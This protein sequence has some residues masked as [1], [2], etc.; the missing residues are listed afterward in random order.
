MF[1]PDKLQ[2]RVIPVDQI[3]LDPNNPRL[4]ALDPT[5][6]RVPDNRVSEPRVQEYVLAQMME[7]A[8]AVRP[9]KRS[10]RQVGFLKMDKI[11]V[12]PLDSGRYVVVEGNRRVAAIKALLRDHDTG[13]DTLPDEL[14]EQLHQLEV[15]VLTT[16]AEEASKDQWLLQGL[17]HISGVK[18]WGPYQRAKALETLVQEMGYDLRQAA[19][20]VGLG[21]TQAARALDAIV[22]L[23]RMHQDPQYGD[24]ATPDMYS[25]FEEVMKRPDLRNWLGWHREEY[26]QDSGFDNYEN[27]AFFY[28][29][30]T[31]QDDE[32]PKINRAIDVRELANVVTNEDS[33]EELMRPEGSLVRA[34][35]MTVE[36]ERA[37]WERHVRRAIEALQTMPSNILESLSTPQ[38][39]LVV[40]L[41][42]VGQLRLSQ[43]RM[44]EEPRRTAEQGVEEEGSL[45]E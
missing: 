31:P 41:I 7:R 26:W 28:S 34:V 14:L 33:L 23:E 36:A 20:T 4:L 42:S 9:L 25:Y 13:R 11:V 19:D 43:A 18:A 44:L 40:E 38:R 12:R 27:L 17:R 10:I 30:I 29:W 35:A 45:G 2:S 8:L 21:P 32:D 39:E 37:D 6:Q 5:A 22:A 16:A 1:D 15:L 24:C 3:L